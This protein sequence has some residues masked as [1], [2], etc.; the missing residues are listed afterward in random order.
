[1]TAATT[2]VT[3]EPKA[4]VWEDFLDIFYAPAQVFARRMDGKFGLAL[5]ILVILSAVL[6][7]AAAQV[8]E[9]AITGELRRGMAQN[10]DVTPEQMAAFSGGIGQWF[11]LGTAIVMMP[12]IV[13]LT[14]L[15]LWLVGK[16]FDSTQSLGQS[17]M[18]ATYANVPKL[19]GLLLMTVQGLLMDV[20]TADRLYDVGFSPARFAAEGSSELVL[21]LLSRF[22]IFVLW[23]TVLL[24]IGLHITGKMPKGKAM[25]VAF[26]VWALAALPG[27]L[28]ALRS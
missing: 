7:Y 15:A 13:L 21:V 27:V 6:W 25:I 23:A 18:V 28:G 9:P 19:L 5:L 11:F 2:P 16:L 22:E 20:S 24:G 12:I 3:A 8:L 26:L 4:S 10:P 14:G 17:V 1:M